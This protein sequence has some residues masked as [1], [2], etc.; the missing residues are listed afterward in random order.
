M[1]LPIRRRLCRR[2]ADQQPMTNVLHSRTAIRNRLDLCRYAPDV[3]RVRWRV[4]DGPIAEEFATDEAWLR[5]AYGSHGS[6]VYSICRRALGAEA[7]KDATQ[8][9]FVNAWRAREQFDPTRG[10]LSAWLVG[11]TKRRIIDNLR[12]EG[13]HADRR[14]DE[15]PDGPA[16]G[17]SQPP[18]E[19]LADRMLVADAL[20]T[21]P[22]RAREVIELAYIHDLTH[23]DIAKRTGIPLGTIKS[24]IRRGLLS[25]REH[26]EASN[27]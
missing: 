7:A 6:L 2:S 24:D 26:M 27:V 25:I 3:E 13:R 21:L 9:V 19:R 12:R 17:G 10:S 23:I 1:H 14:A 18:V 5:D 8:E 15:R 20:A 16:G 4:Q 11:I 22:T